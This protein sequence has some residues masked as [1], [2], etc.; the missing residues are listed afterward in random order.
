MNMTPRE[1]DPKEGS[2]KGKERSNKYAIFIVRR[3][4][5]FLLP[6]ACFA[7]LL[8]VFAG[9]SGAVVLYKEYHI[10]LVIAILVYSCIGI[11]LETLNEDGRRRY[12]GALIATGTLLPVT[13][14]IITVV[15]YV[16]G[17]ADPVRCVPEGKYALFWGSAIAVWAWLVAAFVCRRFADAENAIHSSYGEFHRRFCQV[18]AALQVLCPKVL[19][20][21]N[22]SAQCNN[23]T[24]DAACKEIQCQKEQIENEL[25]RPGPPWV[26]ATGYIN[27]WGRLYSAEEA[28]I[29]ITSQEEVVRGAIYDELR[30]EGSDIDV[31]Q[32]DVLLAKLRQ[33]VCII[34][35]GATQFLK[36]SPTVTTPISIRTTSPLPEGLVNKE[37]NQLLH[38]T[39]GT[40]PYKW[41]TVGPTP[42]KLKPNEDGAIRFTPKDATK[43]PLTFTVR[44]TDSTGHMVDKTFTLNVTTTKK[45]PA[46]PPEKPDPKTVA[47]A[48]LRTLRSSL[49]EYRGG[50][51]NG[52]ILARNRL[53]ATMFLTA[54]MVYLLLV[55]ALIREAQKDAVFTASIFYLVGATIG[56]CSRLRSE[57]ENKTGVYDYG[58]SAAGLITVP[59]FSGL[60][61]IGGVF[62]IAMLPYAGQI[63]GPLHSAPLTINTAPQLREGTVGVAYFEQL[64]A[65][66][67]TE[68]YK[69]IARTDGKG[70]IPD[71]L[72]LSD[73]GV[74][75][76]TPTNEGNGNFTVQVI[77]N[78]GNLVEKMFMLRINPL[79]KPPS[80]LAISSTS[81]LSVGTVGKFYSER[82]LATGGEPP[83]KWKV[84]EDTIT[85]E[86]KE[87]GLTL[88]E[89][90]GVLRGKPTGA[91]KFIF[92]LR[93]TD[94]T[95]YLIEKPFTTLT[96][97]EPEQ[98]PRSNAA[99]GAST[100][101][102]IPSLNDI[103]N[104]HKNLGGILIAVIFG[105]TP[106]LFFDRLK[107]LTDKYKEDLKNSQPTQGKQQT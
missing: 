97:T 104:L 66:G 19:G 25:N 102:S 107:Q 43:D 89:N 42:D 79:P 61:A 18:K 99:Q 33:A 2:S 50:R 47:R 68:P 56:L 32:R 5:L 64:G 96:I 27:V 10:Q 41:S 72:A 14:V 75:S 82:L 20:D 53:M 93:V 4:G 31:K 15:I 49:N 60:T 69:W 37:Y 103:F 98:I 16:I 24:I 81:P 23:P 9:N 35:P 73:A 80:E 70:A 28:L 67:G 91:K 85:K 100:A 38:A 34:D 48:V 78:T 46:K 106:G 62:L 30:L 51:W 105:L 36:T 59:V 6:L 55:I 65:T 8:A 40:P 44:V 77:D 17:W 74:L 83:Y 87:S 13:L 57:F 58:L 39:G 63:I 26:L 101:G 94:N 84:V 86:L 71:G 54:L 76:G 29:E 95:K 11:L 21:S 92:T 7:G 22:K 90:T 1:N 12:S 88:D 52:L 3:V 45:A